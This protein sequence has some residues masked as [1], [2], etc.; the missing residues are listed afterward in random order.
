MLN[1]KANGV[2]SVTVAGTNWT[3]MPVFAT[4]AWT[5]FQVNAPMPK[6]VDVVGNWVTAN[7]VNDVPSAVIATT[8]AP[9]TGG[10]D[11]GVSLFVC[12]VAGDDGTRPGTVPANFWDT[13]LIFL[14]NPANGN[15]ET[16]A[17]LAAS[18]EYYLTAVIGNRGSAA[19]GHY[20]T[21][22]AVKIEAAG[23]VMVWNTGMS[24]AVQLPALSNLDVN[25]TNGFGEVYFLRSG[26]YDVVGFR[27]NVQTV[28]DGLVAAIAASGMNLGGL[29]PEQWVHAQGAHLCA[30]VLVRTVTDSWP[31][32][33]D[34][35]FTDRRL[36]QKNLAPFA[37][38]L[39][40][41]SSNPN[42]IWKNFMV[43]DV[44]QFV[45]WP[46]GF[47][48]GWGRHKLMIR[49]KLPPGAL[50]LYFAVP[51]QSFARW[52]QPAA[53][54]GFKQ[55]DKKSLRGLKAPF[56]EHVILM[57]TGKENSIELPA[58]RGEFLGMSL[59]FEYDVKKLQPKA[60]GTISVIQQTAVPK[61]D[62]R[63]KCYEIEPVIVGGFTFKLEV[64]DSRKT[65]EPG[66]KNCA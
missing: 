54:K 15:I 38:N 21:P 17:D 20:M 46:G 8:P 22:S 53:I 14:V 58:L 65:R 32:V 62:S 47:D 49:A 29:T 28:F 34:T 19:G 30:K 31:L 5:D 56:P 6:L 1:G 60:E 10:L 3:A 42:I 7:K 11:A 18:A 64:Y 33:G 39:A 37:V 61:V 4:P 2:P 23:W 57:L 50:R 35:P 55:V 59:G 41:S 36:A 48:E 40:A 16:P 25:S 13:S 27:L 66:E 51:K 43:G 26:E 44:F 24:P 52:F 9:I 63:R 45:H 12:S